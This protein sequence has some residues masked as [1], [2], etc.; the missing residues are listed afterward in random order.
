MLIVMS[1]VTPQNRR[2]VALCYDLIWC[3]SS[4]CQAFFPELISFAK[5]KFVV[6]S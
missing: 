6:E 1:L 4:S 2:S 5:T 3:G